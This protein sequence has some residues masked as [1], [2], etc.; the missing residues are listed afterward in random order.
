MANTIREQ[1]LIDSNKRTL[2]KYVII[3]DGTQEANTIL[4]D[5]SSLAYSLNANGY[6]MQSNVHPKATYRTSVKKV[7]A[8]GKVSGTIRLKWQGDA[9]SEFVVFGS[10]VDVGEEG[11][12]V[13]ITNPEGNTSGDILIST[14]GLASGDALTLFIDLKKDNADFDAGQTA[15]PYDFN[16]G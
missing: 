3:S 7:K 6:I 10:S 5:A 11:E 14:V 1:K 9:N 4:L 12:S 2:V 13:L 16:R 8:F 15:R